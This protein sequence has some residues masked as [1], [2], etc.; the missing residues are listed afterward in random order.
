MRVG[1]QKIPSLPCIIFVCMFSFILGTTMVSIWQENIFFQKNIFNVE[2]LREI[3]NVYIDKRALFFLCLKERLGAF[4]IMFL[5]S[6]T[7][8][9]IVFV[10]SY[11]MLHGFAIGCV[12]EVL[13]IRYGWSGV[14]IYLSAVL[15]YYILYAIGYLILG[16]WCLNRE[17]TET[18]DNL[19]E[20]KLGMIFI[21]FFINL[22]GIYIESAFSLKIFSVILNV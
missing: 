18:K 2:F 12:V 11:F 7:I 19:S 3:S 15:P 21:A 10:F 4:F 8:W 9:N 6:S 22:L 1:K 14:T 13:I 20:R 17:K 16:C 5:V